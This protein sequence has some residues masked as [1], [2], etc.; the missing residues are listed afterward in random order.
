MKKTQSA[1][2]LDGQVALVTASG[3]GIGKAC[4]LALAQA[5]ADVILGLKH[6][7]AGQALVKQIQKMG[8]EVLPVQMDVTDKDEIHDAVQAGL[9]HFK[10][11]DILVNN[12]G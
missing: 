4:A 9:R 12:A 8:R 7:S 6:K 3:K 2:T 10:R 1:F 5:G 11:I